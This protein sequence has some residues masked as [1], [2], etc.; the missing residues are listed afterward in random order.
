MLVR[1]V[2]PARV[3]LVAL[4]LQLAELRLDGVVP[5]KRRL[6]L[7]VVEL[8]EELVCLRALSLDSLPLGP[9]TLNYPPTP[10]ALANVSECTILVDK[11]K[12]VGLN[13]FL[14]V[15]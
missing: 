14:Q 11:L 1:G 8:L 12:A 9:E 7:G 10:L 13:L 4:L 15:P 2:A 6:G 5:S 3:R